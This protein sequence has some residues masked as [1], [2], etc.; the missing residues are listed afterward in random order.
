[1]S[2][3]LGLAR[4][5][6]I[7]MG[8]ARSLTAP[9]DDVHL[10][11]VASEKLTLLH[12]GVA[13]THYR[14]LLAFE[15]SAVADRAVADAPAPELLLTRHAQVARQSARGHDQSGGAQLLARFEAHHLGHSLDVDLLDRF[16]V[17]YLEAEL[18]GVV[19]HLGRQLR[20][21]DRLKAR[22]VLHQL[23]VQELSAE[24]SP[25]D[26]HSLQVHPCRVE[27]CRQTGRAAPHD[28]HVVAAH[29]TS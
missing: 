24:R 3:T 19:A 4:A 21:E 23:G 22:V 1:M 9:V 20:A 6:S 7:R 5:L 12:R 13:A 27:A 2:S 8:W 15:E 17:P 10:R 11:R 18:A 25:V 28:D 14:Q 29:C 16:E 26:Q